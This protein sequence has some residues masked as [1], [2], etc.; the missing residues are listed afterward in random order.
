MFYR[1]VMQGRALGGADVDEV[2]RHF[3]RVTG[4]P[5]AFAEQLFGGIPQIIKRQVPQT[6]AER[7]AATLRAIGAAATVEPEPPAAE[8]ETP[9]GIQVVAAPLNA[10]PPTIIPGAM[11]PPPSAPVPSRH[12]RWL[13]LLRGRWSLLRDAFMLAALAILLTP[14]V[15]DLLAEMRHTS[16]PARVAPKRTPA[17]EVVPPAPVM[18]ATLMYGPWRCT[19]QRTGVST[20]WSYGANGALIFHGDVLSDAPA[21]AGAA[22][23]APN[24]WKLEGQRLFH[25]FAQRAPDIYTVAQLT[26][27]RLRY[28]DERDFDIE[29]RRP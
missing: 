19:D 27:A 14:V 4:L 3:V 24:G 22:A 2:K 7:I 10:G 13:R 5:A 6:D 15:E 21:P 26:L 1:V 23:S 8:A 25:T 9:E 20:Y 17:A 18:V 16:A 29:C 28:G 11:A 12:T